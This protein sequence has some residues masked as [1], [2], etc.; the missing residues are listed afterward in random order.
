MKALQGFTVLLVLQAVGEALVRVLGLA[1]PGPVVGLLL[2]LLCL[3]FGWLQAMV[4]AMAP[5]LLQHLSLLF[6]P[7]GVGVLTYLAVL[8]QYGW[9]IVLVLVASTWA[10]LAATAL[11]MRWTSERDGHA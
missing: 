8:Q 5:T 1:L 7:V 6:V 11:V 10:G 3:R 4:G 2:L 9:R